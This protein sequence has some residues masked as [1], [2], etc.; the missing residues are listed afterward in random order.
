ME[1]LRIEWTGEATNEQ[2]LKLNELV[3]D[4]VFK[5]VPYELIGKRPNDRG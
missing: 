3:N 4:P 5:D 2:I 1:K